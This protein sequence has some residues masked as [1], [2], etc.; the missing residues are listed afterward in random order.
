[1]P[2]MQMKQMNDRDFLMNIVNLN[3]W[4]YTSEEL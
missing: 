1:M 2:K 4:K 3:I